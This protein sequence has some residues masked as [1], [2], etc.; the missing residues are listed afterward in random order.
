MLYVLRYGSW[1]Y[2]RA[3]LNCKEKKKYYSMRRTSQSSSSFSF[4]NFSISN[5][6]E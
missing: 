6:D 2:M 4:N 3:Q 5:K 1:F